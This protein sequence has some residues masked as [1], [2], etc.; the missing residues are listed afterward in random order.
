MKIKSQYPAIVTNDAEKVLNS[1]TK[2]GFKIVHTQKDILFDGNVEYVLKHTT[3]TKMDV[4]Q[5]KVD[6]E[7]QGLRL[8]V[9]DVEQAIKE[10]SEDGFKVIAG[11]QTN[12]YSI[13]ALMK[14]DDGLVIYI[15]Q[16][17]R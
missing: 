5:A 15:M 10:F 11:P 4:V 6:F 7:K 17:K 14:D 9:T 2:K 3:G 16:H 1:L 8:N 13:S 12:K